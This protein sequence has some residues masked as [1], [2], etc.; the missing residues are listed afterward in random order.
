MKSE[1]CPTLCAHQTS[2]SNSGW[3]ILKKTCIV[4]L[5]SLVISVPMQ[6]NEYWGSVPA[7][8]VGEGTLQEDPNGA[9]TVTSQDGHSNS[10]GYEEFGQTPEILAAAD[11][12]G[13]SYLLTEDP[14]PWRFVDNVYNFVRNKIDVE[15]MFGTK[16]GAFGTLLDRSGT[17]FDQVVLM[18]EILH[19]AGVTAD[20]KLGTITVSTEQAANWLGS[21]KYDGT[22]D[23]DTLKT[24]LADGGIPADVDETS[25]VILHLWIEV[26]ID[27]VKREFD[28]SFKQYDYRAG[29]NLSTVLNFTGDDVIAKAATG[30]TAGTDG[31]ARTF[32]NVNEG[33]IDTFL[34]GK[35]ADFISW[36]ESNAEGAVTGDILGDRKIITEE[37]PVGGWLVTPAPSNLSARAGAHWAVS[38]GVPD[39]FRTKLKLFM[40]DVLYQDLGAPELL[41][42]SFFPYAEDLVPFP[43]E[44][45]VVGPEDWSLYDPDSALLFFTD[46]I[47]GRRLWVDTARRLVDLQLELKLDDITLATASFCQPTPEGCDVTSDPGLH[48]ANRWASDIVLEIDHPYLDNFADERTRFDANYV[49]PIEILIGFGAASETLAAYQSSKIYG[50]ERLIPIHT[51]IP[52]GDSTVFDTTPLFKADK[53][54]NQAATAWLLQASRMRQLQARVAN[55]STIHH[56]SIGVVYSMSELISRRPEYEKKS[57]GGVQPPI[58]PLFRPEFEE[59]KIQGNSTRINVSTKA[60]IRVSSGIEEQAGLR[61]AV[62]ATSAMLE[63]SVF[64]QQMGE[65]D[66][67]STTT[68]AQWA[69]LYQA[70]SGCAEMATSVSRFA[71]E[72]ET[73]EI[74]NGAWS[75]GSRTAGMNSISMEYVDPVSLTIGPGP[76]CQTTSVGIGISVKHGGIALETGSLRVNSFGRGGAHISYNDDF[77]EFRHVVVTKGVLSKGGGGAADFLS[78]GNYDPMS[79]VDL[80]ADVFEDRSSLHGISLKTGV[81]NFAPSADITTGSGVGA[82]SFQRYFTAGA[83]STTGMPDG[84]THNWDYSAN[85]SGSAMEVMTSLDARRAAPAVVAFWAMQKAY[86]EMQAPSNPDAELSNL[87]AQLTGLFVNNWWRKSLVHN[88]V[89]V[90]RGQDVETHVKVPYKSGGTVTSKWLAPLGSANKLTVTGKPETKRPGSGFVRNYKYQS[91]SMQWKSGAGDVIA[92]APVD[93]GPV[94]TDHLANQGFNDHEGYREGLFLPSTIDFIDGPDITFTWTGDHQLK[95]VSNAYNRSLTFSYENEGAY[96]SGI[97][98]RLV[99]VS[100]E[101]DR[102][103]TLQ[104]GRLGL[105]PS[106]YGFSR[107]VLSAVM[108]PDGAKW[109]YTWL[110]AGEKLATMPAEQSTSYTPVLH[111]VYDPVETDQGIPMI[112]VDYDVS[113]RPKAITTLAGQ[114]YHFNAVADHGGER[115][116]PDNQVYSAYYDNHQIADQTFDPDYDLFTDEEGAVFKAYQDARGRVTG[117]VDADGYRLRFE[118]DNFNNV[119]GLTKFEKGATGSLTATAEYGGVQ[120]SGATTPPVGAENKPK[121]VVDFNGEETAFCYTAEGRV[122]KVTRPSVDD[123]EIR[124]EYAYLSDGRLDWVKN[125]E[126][127]VTKYTY[128][129]ASGLAGYGLIASEVLDHGGLNSTTTYAYDRYGNMIQTD[130]PLHEP[131]PEPSAGPSGDII[132]I[133]YDI[134]RRPVAVVEGKISPALSTGQVKFAVE[135]ARIG[136]YTDTVYD[137]MGRTVATN[138]YGFNYQGNVVLPMATQWVNNTYKVTVD[139]ATGEKK[140]CSGSGQPCV[141]QESG[142]IKTYYTYDSNDRVSKV[143]QQIDG[144][145]ENDRYTRTAYDV[146]GRAEAVFKKLTNTTEI[147]YQTYTYSD[148]GRLLTVDDANNNR[149]TYHYDGYGRLS[150][151]EFPDKE[152]SLQSN[153]ADFEEYKYDANGNVIAKRT[154][155]GDWVVSGYDALNRLNKKSLYRLGS[156]DD[157]SQALTGGTLESKVDYKYMRDDR[158]E[159]I[160]QTSYSPLEANDNIPAVTI[161]N[162]SLA[163]GYD[164]AGRMTAETVSRRDE[165]NNHLYS[166]TVEI[167]LDEAGARTQLVLPGIIDGTYQTASEVVD[168]EYDYFGRMTKIT[169]GSNVMLEYQY[170]GFGRREAM[171]RKP[172][173]A[174][175]ISTSYRYSNDNAL[176]V[177]EHDL[178]NDQPWNVRFAFD[179]NNARQITRK[180]VSNSSYVFTPQETGADYSVNGLNQYEA[181]QIAGEQNPVELEYDGNG[182]LMRDGSDRYDYDVQN[183]L[184]RAYSTSD[185]TRATIYEYGPKGRRFAKTKKGDNIRTEFLYEGDEPVADYLIKSINNNLNSFSDDRP[186]LSRRY[187]NGAGV[188]ERVAYMEY[189]TNNGNRTLLNYYVTDY[190]GSVIGQI[191]DSDG[192]FYGSKAYTYEPYGN[193]RESDGVGQPFR[194]TGRRWDEETRLYYYRARYYSA[195]LGRFLQTDPI[196]Y[197]DN[198]NLYAYTNNDPINMTDPTGLRSWQSTLRDRIKERQQE[199]AENREQRQADRL[200]TVNKR[201]QS[202]IDGGNLTDATGKAFQGQVEAAAQNAPGTGAAV[203]VGK[204]GGGALMLLGA[205]IDIAE[206]GSLEGRADLDVRIAGAVVEGLGDIATTTV[207][208]GVM[209]E[210][211][212]VGAVAGGFSASMSYTLSGTGNQVN[213]T[214]R[215][216]YVS[217]T[218]PLMNPA[219]L[220]R[221]LIDTVMLQGLGGNYD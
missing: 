10:F 21:M 30:A 156:W 11:A 204:A 220:V 26:E 218:D 173:T 136:T 146:T 209:A 115:I 213:Q 71:L 1:T 211:G 29:V 65:V 105:G 102:A 6:A 75:R 41:I 162:M 177:L 109:T 9:Y 54:I 161:P 39:V 153:T 61:Q 187:I 97:I 214:G 202:P 201:D 158:D 144:K 80:L 120:C 149:T 192:T 178:E 51:Y 157:A 4:A 141:V 124:F 74:Q 216:G 63:A 170:D 164:T 103:V 112:R 118:Y 184:V 145:V 40:E 134:M 219:D 82:L 36:I 197:E 189:N 181:I 45:Q 140:Y 25:A 110:G 208:A 76:E 123:E 148:A 15:P 133:F 130:G 131:V 182:S 62:A 127:I 5:A 93:F 49:E 221:D 44:G 121:K 47:Y 17:P 57:E 125:P 52:N 69:N 2:A 13:K 46:E 114:Q 91:V 143:T 106:R 198:M 152:T 128:H 18:G 50:K 79:S 111:K 107:A 117:R 203:S 129:A 24:H 81:L 167:E 92:F 89:T 67:V 90:R 72:N 34:D 35:A 85:F 206:E 183:R 96:P 137:K 3:S 88:A 27:G 142:G 38:D 207:G 200:G 126:N 176:S 205:T 37:R 14:D 179:R 135:A 43:Y 172:A 191:Q 199:R 101:N 60:S 175:K 165:N 160:T 56:H 32:K 12:L 185:P 154:R 66:T 73:S 31:T 100:D 180:V 139:Q 86:S 119:T 168:F 190:Q 196:G 42:A 28:P 20:Y 23:V 116:D 95:S 132:T 147:A 122:Q 169:R 212:P 19:A 94:H 68:R 210:L 108:M 78:Q 7:F 33:L 87:K 215:E 64:E 8:R 186:R 22:Y 16:K 70:G 194:Y 83:G 99:S 195:N 188:D 193:P 53:V 151:T 59:L 77:T 104:W 174:N 48:P 217:F 58:Q 55:G 155:N 150:K 84:W 159:L 166:Y 113:W 98:R 163:Y 138:T 171:V